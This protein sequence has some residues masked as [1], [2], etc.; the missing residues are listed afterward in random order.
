MLK[1]VHNSV[2]AG[3]PHSFRNLRPKLSLPLYCIFS[4]HGIIARRRV[5]S[6]TVL[7]SA[8]W[9]QLPGLYLE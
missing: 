5:K 1:D 2:R 3:S 9:G 8:V 4:A 6:G 7:F